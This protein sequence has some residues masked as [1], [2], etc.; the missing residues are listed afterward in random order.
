[1]DKFFTGNWSAYY[2]AMLVLGILPN[3]NNQV[4][5]FPILIF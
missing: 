4:Y 2:E 1:M 3:A 5:D